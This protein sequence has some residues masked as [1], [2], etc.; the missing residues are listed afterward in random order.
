MIGCGCAAAQHYVTIKTVG[1][2]PATLPNEFVQMKLLHVAHFARLAITTCV[3]LTVSFPA[4]SASLASLYERAKAQDLNFVAAQHQ[5]DAALE[6]RP[7]ALAAVLPQLS[8][9]ADARYNRFKVVSVNNPTNTN[10]R[11]ANESYQTQSYSLQISQIV[12][13]WSAFKALDAADSNVAQ[14]EATYRAAEQDMI[15]RYVSAYLEVLAAQ[16]A[17]QADLDA[18]AAFKQTLDQQDSK[19]KG[20]VAS[21]TDVRNAQA[22]YDSSTATVI[23]STT[24][25]NNAKRALSLIVGQPVERVDPLREDIALVPPVPIDVESWV[26]AAKDKGLAVIAARHAAEAAKRNISSVSGRRLPTLSLVGSAGRDDSGSRFGYDSE[27]QYVGVQLGWDLY[28]GGQIASSVREAEANYELANTRYELQLRTAERNARD[29]YE[30]VVS[31]IAAVRAA[32][33]AVRSHQASVVATEVGFKVGSRTIIDTLNVRQSLANAQKA[34]SRARTGYLASL[35]R[36]KGSVGQLSSRDV[37]DIDNLLDPS[38]SFVA[39]R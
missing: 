13:D 10:Y 9:Q 25:L 15:V 21:V 38:R 18:Q 32:S 30:G 23:N 12:F 7:Q 19:F 20:G 24:A 34:A 3:L 29:Q 37:V 33:S 39:P 28:R 8:A 35:L 2:A 27:T 14:A 11:E 6:A 17:L 4:H 16:D 22:S 5:R 31:G 1:P 26:T 36:L